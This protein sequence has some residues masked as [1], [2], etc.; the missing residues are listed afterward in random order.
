[1]KGE[2][3]ENRGFGGPTRRS[4]FRRIGAKCCSNTRC[5]RHD[6]QLYSA[7]APRR[8]PPPVD[9]AST[10][11]ERSLSRAGI[12][13]EHRESSVKMAALLKLDR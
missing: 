9:G 2:K 5:R 12:A 11:V 10:L 4:E 13:R 8:H 6:C 3:V 7:A 1:M